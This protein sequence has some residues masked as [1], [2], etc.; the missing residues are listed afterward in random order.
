M[1]FHGPESVVGLCLK[2]KHNNR[3]VVLQSSKMHDNGVVL[4]TC[5]DGTLLSDYDLEN[6]WIEHTEEE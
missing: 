2:N 5:E 6:H 3:E 1:H 4:Y